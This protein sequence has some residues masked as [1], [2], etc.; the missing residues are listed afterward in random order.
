MPRSRAKK[1]VFQAWYPWVAVAIVVGFV[2]VAYATLRGAVD[3]AWQDTEGYLGHGLYVREHGGWLGW[4]RQSFAGT[5]PISERHPLYL[6]LIAPFAIRDAAYFA[7]AKQVNLL[8]GVAVLVSFLW[9]TRRRYGPGPSLLAGALYA[10]SHSLLVASAHVNNETLFTLTTLWTWWFLTGAR[11]PRRWIAA[12]VSAGLAW[13]TKSPAILLILAAG[14]A[15]LWETRGTAMRARWAWGFI[16]ALMLVASPWWVNNLRQYGTPLYEGVNTHIM[17]LDRWS[18]LGD[19][20]SSMYRDPYGIKTIEQNHLPDMRAYLARHSLAGILRR[21]FKGYYQEVVIVARDALRPMVALPWS[22]SVFWGWGVLA[23]GVYG[24]WRQPVPERL[25]VGL[26][27]LAFL[28]F[29]A[30]DAQMFPDFRYLAPLVPIYLA[31]AATV[32]WVWA[33]NRYGILRAVQVT[34]V[35]AAAIVGAAGAWVLATGQVTAPQP[36]LRVSPA[37]ERLVAWVDRLPAGSGLVVGPTTEFYGYWWQV[38]TP[39]R[40]YQPPQVKTR[41]A[42]LDYLARRGIT[43]LVIHPENVAGLYGALKAALAAHWYVA[44]DGSIQER[45]PLP[46]WTQVLADPGTPSRFLI[47][48]TVP[49]DH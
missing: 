28:T 30:W 29:F 39:V 6:L 13:L 46:G 44:K 2:V 36:L 32:L 33:V 20:A 35:S 14:L 43:T 3:P 38:R 4:L 16:V 21:L 10:V 9:M 31:Y 40:L 42:F 1:S 15:A 8:L 27:T 12:G 5:Y 47:Y 48:Q 18:E 25:F 41:Q 23:V 49:H 7:A 22:L 26:W 11:T 19:P 45:A 24:W 17:W 37:Y 34:A